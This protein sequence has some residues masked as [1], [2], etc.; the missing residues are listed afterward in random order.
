[1]Y[2]LNNSI[3]HDQKFILSLKLKMLQGRLF[4][5]YEITQPPLSSL[6]GFLSSGM[7]FTSGSSPDLAST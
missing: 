5:F 7:P 4:C 2:M 6:K 1:M 3:I